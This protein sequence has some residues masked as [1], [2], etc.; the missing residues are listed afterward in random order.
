MVGSGGFLCLVLLLN[1]TWGYLPVCGKVIQLT[2]GRGEGKHSFYCGC[3]AWSPGSLCLKG[4]NS[5]KVFRGR[6]LKTECW[7]GVVGAVISAW[8]SF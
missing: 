3:Q 8:T 4:L 2:R 6:F 1:Q 7:K 5:L